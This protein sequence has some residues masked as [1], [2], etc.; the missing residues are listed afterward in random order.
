MTEVRN[1]YR[2]DK[3]SPCVAKKKQLGARRRRSSLLMI[4]FPAA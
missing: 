3:A 2:I 4:S 1:A